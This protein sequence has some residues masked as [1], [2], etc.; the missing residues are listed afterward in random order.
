[1]LAP[2][3][4]LR[5]PHIGS[6][7]KPGPGQR[8]GV[9]DKQVGRRPAVRSRT[10]VRL[11][12][13][14]NLRAF[15]RDEAVATTVPLTGTETKPAVVGKGS[16]QV[17]NGEDWRYSRTHNCNLSTDSVGRIPLTMS[18]RVDRRSYVF[19][20]F[21]VMSLASRERYSRRKA[22]QLPAVTARSSAMEA[23]MM[24]GR[25]WSS[26]LF[27]QRSMATRSTDMPA[28]AAKVACSSP[29]PR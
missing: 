8:L 12:A 6:G 25:L 20:S 13:E 11:H 17:A 28:P 3:G 4:V 26:S 10:E 27:A 18:S 14:M 21:G 15:E 5:E 23:F 29:T 7:R 19:G 22:A 9:L 1:M 2:V 16:G 24:T